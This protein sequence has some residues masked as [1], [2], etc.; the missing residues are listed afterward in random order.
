MNTVRATYTFI[1]GSGVSC[2]AKLPNVQKL[3][4]AVTSAVTG[5][6]A[7]L[8]QIIKD[9]S[10][11]TH[12]DGKHSYEDWFFVAD[13]LF[14]HESGDFENPGL[15]SL[16]ERLRCSLDLT[17]DEI[18]DSADRLCITIGNTVSRQ[19]RTKDAHL[20]AAFSGLADAIRQRER[21]KFHFFSL[22]HDLLLE[23]YLKNE[24]FNPYTGTEQHPS[25][26]AYQ[27]VRFSRA[28]FDAAPISVT[29]LHGSVDW[30]RVRPRESR[31]AFNSWRGE[32][33]GVQNEND[34]AFEGMDEDSR[35][36]TGTSNKILRY[37]SPLFLPMFAQ[38]HEC[39]REAGCV[40]VC[41]YGFAD[42][43]INSLLIDSLCSETGPRLIVIDPEPFHPSRCREAV[44]GKVEIWQSEGK[45]EPPIARHV[46]AN[47][48]TWTEIL[49]VID[50]R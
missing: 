37:S 22:N 2:A 26:P 10:A 24:G 36:L 1:I 19:L 29:K 39:L 7:R 4:C 6:E 49:E 47:D 11:A 5:S 32:F 45:L 9:L 17:N 50:A 27:R 15:S 28:A 23:A 13:Q 14:Q 34:P 25:T 31:N 35:I 40:V 41:G 48:M 3:S 20:D 30:Q 21:A 46:G 42:K 44:S 16:M 38:F 8:L 33:I 43:G 18:M 12:G